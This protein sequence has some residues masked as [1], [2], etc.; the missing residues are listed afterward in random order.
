MNNLK[1]RVWDYT[2]DKMI[3]FEGIFNNRPYEETSTFPQY[4]SCPKFH[5][6]S[7]IMLFTGCQ[8]KFKKDIYVDDYFEDK[9]GNIY[10]VKFWSCG[11]WLEPIM[12]AYEGYELDLVHSQNVLGRVIGNEF[13]GFFAEDC[14]DIDMEKVRE[15]FKKL[16]DNEQMSEKIKKE[17]KKFD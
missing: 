1:S 15:Q 8:D 2:D 14:D 5:E 17:L 7:N 16:V 4:E 13:E 10:K 12:E 6:L 9:H 11:F 3:F